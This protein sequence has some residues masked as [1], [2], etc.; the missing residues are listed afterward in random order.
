MTGGGTVPERPVMDMGTGT[1]AVGQ[2]KGIS[3][4]RGPGRTGRCPDPGARDDAPL[5]GPWSRPEEPPPGRVPPAAGEDAPVPGQ[6]KEG[7]TPAPLY[8]KERESPAGV[9]RPEQGKPR[10]RRKPRRQVERVAE[11]GEA[12]HRAPSSRAQLP[13]GDGDVPEPAC[14]APAAVKGRRAHPLLTPRNL[15]AAV[16]LSEVLDHRGGRQAGRGRSFYGWFNR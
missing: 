4:C 12:G 5:P 2:G 8:E 6:R 13:A 9:D 16:L 10:R 11:K 1:G 7:E 3:L 15:A 14:P